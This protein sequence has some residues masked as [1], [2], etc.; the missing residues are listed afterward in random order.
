MAAPLRAGALDELADRSLAW[1]ELAQEPA[2]FTSYGHRDSA[3]PPSLELR[4]RAAYSR[5]SR[6]AIRAELGSVRNMP[7]GF[8]EEED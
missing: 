2:R 7:V 6:S 4:Q 8:N 3:S 5:G 1:D